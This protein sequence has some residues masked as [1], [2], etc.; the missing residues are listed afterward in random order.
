MT[1]EAA[2]RWALIRARGT[3]QRMRVF[4]HRVYVVTPDGVRDSWAYRVGPADPW[5]DA[6]PGGAV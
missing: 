1:W 3:G 6:W 2:M 5:A 4:S